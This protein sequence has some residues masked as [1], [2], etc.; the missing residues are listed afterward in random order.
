MDV[1]IGRFTK[2]EC[3]RWDW[4]DEARNSKKLFHNL[5]QKRPK[6]RSKSRRK[7]DVA[8]DVRYMDIVNWRQVAQI[9]D[10]W[11][12]ATGEA[13]NF[14]GQWSHIIIIIIIIII[15]YFTSN[16]LSHWNSNEKLKEKFRSC[17]RK[18]FDR[19]TTKDSYTWNIT[20]NMES[21]AV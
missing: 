15:N 17:T 5:H 18:T 4:K 14:L 12:I 19:F 13:L 10:G 9:G 8:N 6:G 16:N 20:L 2:P 11:R 3:S 1:N 7:D 21:T